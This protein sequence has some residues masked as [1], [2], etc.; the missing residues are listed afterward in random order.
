[1]NIK[2]IESKQIHKGKYISFYSDK[3]LINNSIKAVREYMTYPPAVGIIPVLDNGNIVMVEQYRY[4][5]DITSLEIPAGKIAPNEDLKI[6]SVRELEEETGFK[7]S[8]E[9]LKQIYT[10]TPAIS[11][12][13]EKLTLFIAKNLKKGKAKPDEDEFINVITLPVSKIMEK[14]DNNEIMD[15]KTV[16]AMLLYIRYEKI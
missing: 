6:A 15:S 13:T 10:Y 11:Y 8:P 16:L 4:T 2:K 1:M 14:I 9:D 12:S 7:C 3:I 5:N